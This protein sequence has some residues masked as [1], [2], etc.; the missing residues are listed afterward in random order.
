[1]YLFTRQVLV[2]PGHMRA[3]MAHAVEMLK[4]VNDKTNLDASLYQVLQ[5]APVGTL[6]FSFRTES[7]AA[8]VDAN[9]KLLQ[10]DEYLAKVEAGAAYYVGNAQDQLGE[11]LHVAGEVSEA[12]AVASIVGASIEVAQAS[13][14]VAWAVDLANY[15]QNLAG[16]TTAVVTSNF[17]QYGRISWIG[18]SPSLAD[19]ENAGR[20]LN[21]DPGFLQR[22]ADSKGMFV[23]GSGTGVLS[24]KIA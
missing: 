22:L 3:G 14:A 11:F 20:K 17:G 8:S 12:P 16:Q 24:R 15:T 10:S 7:Y 6:A 2:S 9:D 5:G 1:M 18:Y 21:A 4:Y 19:T 23:P 13:A